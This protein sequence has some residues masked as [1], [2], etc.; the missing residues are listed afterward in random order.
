MRQRS[1]WKLVLLTLL[2]IVMLAAARYLPIYIRYHRQIRAIAA[3]EQLGGVVTSHREPPEWLNRLHPD[4][5]FWVASQRVG[6]NWL[7]EWLP[8]ET[9]IEHFIVVDEV[10]ISNAPNEPGARRIIPDPSGGRRDDR[11]ASAADDDLRHVAAFPRLC[12]LYLRD[13]PITDAGLQNLKD[14]HELKI[15]NLDFTQITDAGM[16][17]VPGLGKLTHVS[18]AGTKITNAGIARLARLDHLMEIDVSATEVSEQGIR[19]FSQR[20]GVKVIS[21]STS[22]R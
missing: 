10:L 19:P 15:L 17:I 11:R 21:D 1:P 12:R 13:L 3:V 16:E 20:A 4:G 9:V 6:P 8:V 5:A 18:V 22:A 14:L 2:S 7:R